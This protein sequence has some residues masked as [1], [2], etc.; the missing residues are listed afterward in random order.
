MLAGRLDA[1]DRLR[2]GG[3]ERRPQVHAGAHACGRPFS[4]GCVAQNMIACKRSSS[5]G[6]VFSPMLCLCSW[7]VCTLRAGWRRRTKRRSWT[8]W[9]GRRP[10][11]TR[12]R[13][14]SRH[15]APPPT[16][17]YTQTRALPSKPT[18][19]LLSSAFDRRA[20]SSLACSFC[21]PSNA[22]HSVRRRGRMARSRRAASGRGSCR[23][24]W[25]RVGSGRWRR[26]SRCTSSSTRISASK[27]HAHSH[28]RAPSRSRRLWIVCG[29]VSGRP[30]VRKRL[31]FAV[32]GLSR[33]TGRLFTKRLFLTRVSGWGRRAVQCLLAA[34]R[35]AE[36]RRPRR[37]ERRRQQ[38][39]RLERLGRCGVGRGRRG[40]QADL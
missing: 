28:S 22:S 1:H 14:P 10:L 25:T 24:S 40:H 15:A 6:C 31:I 11:R 32:V 39:N 30:R 35:R 38:R 8:R 26:A 17:L 12:P 27:V 37:R 13:A 2:S 3:G 9:A 4:M 16:T 36:R 7:A 21:L 29:F 23:R 20:K 18:L 5:L 33:R 34:S 19:R